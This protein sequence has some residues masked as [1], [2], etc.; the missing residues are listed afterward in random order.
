MTRCAG[1]A[2]RWRAALRL[3]QYRR[4]DRLR[5]DAEAAEIRASR[6]DEDHVARPM[7]TSSAMPSEFD[8]V[9]CVRSNFIHEKMEWYRAVEVLEKV[10]AWSIRHRRW[11]AGE[12]ES[13]RSSCSDVLEAVLG[14]VGDRCAAIGV[15]GTF[16]AETLRHNG[17]KNVEVIGCPRSSAPA[18]ATSTSRSLTSARSARSPSA[19]RREA[20]KSYGRSGRLSAQPEGAR[21][22]RST[23]RARW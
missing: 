21:C 2:R 19:C 4:H 13:G 15:R 22:S 12:R 11:R 16:S 7:R 5:L 1:T 9:S 10:A 20:D 8:Y 6:A 18:S 14:I 23:A 3:F 17:I